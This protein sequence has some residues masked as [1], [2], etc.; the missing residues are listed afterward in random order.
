M[1]AITPQMRILVAEEAVDFRKGI[2]SLAELCR[3]KLQTDPFSG[4]LFV[5]RPHLAFYG[6]QLDLARTGQPKPLPVIRCFPLPGNTLPG[7]WRNSRRQRCSTF[8]FTSNARATSPMDTPCSSRWTA[9]S[10]NSLVNIL[11]DNPMTQFSFEWILSLNWL[12]QKWGQVQAASM[13]TLR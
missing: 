1:L 4:C 10:L 6:R 2:D 7:P 13:I 9:A 3:A 11:L 5:F 12:S 8:A